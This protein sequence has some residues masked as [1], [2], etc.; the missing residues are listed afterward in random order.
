[1]ATVFEASAAIA[2]FRR[3]YTTTS[4]VS[5]PVPT[6]TA[7]AGLLAAI[8]GLD[9][10]CQEQ[11]FAA[12]YWQ[13]LQGT[14]IAIQMLA[15]LKWRSETI[16]FWNVKEP[17]KNP[18]IQVKHQFISRPRYRFYVQGGIEEKLKKYL[19]QGTFVYTPY[20]GV[21]Y[22]VADIKYCGHYPWEPVTMEQLDVSTVVPYTGN[23]EVDILSSGGSFRERI[24]FRLNQDRS[25]VET[26]PILYQTDPNKKLRLLKR[27]ELDVT[28][29]GEDIVAWFPAW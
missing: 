20:L 18:H 4:S 28:R 26:L 22:A 17:Q 6:P 11:G 19:S 23:L 14:R 13:Y 1:M 2:M 12:R 29:C 5:Y 27:G 9:N 25:L 15:P 3:P 16:N 10:G 7:V 21:A 24:P 8:T